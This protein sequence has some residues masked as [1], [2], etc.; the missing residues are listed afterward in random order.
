MTAHTGHDPALVALSIAIAVF[1]SYTALDLGGRV[2][3]AAPGRRWAWIGAAAIAMGGGVWAMH[4]IGMLAFDVAMPVAYEVGL[5][6]LSLLIAVG[7]TGAAFAWVG[8]RGAKTGDV[9]LSGPL[10][11]V[12]VASMHYTGMAAMH[13]PGNLAY[14]PPV[15]AL[16]VL[17]AVVAATA[18]L[19][20]TFRQNRV[21]QK[22]VAAG[23]MGIAVAGMHYTG[24]A[25]ASFTAHAGPAAGA[26]GTVGLEQQNLA[27]YVAGVTFL[28]LFLALVA[29]SI[30]QQRV[31]RELVVAKETAEAAKDAAEDARRRLQL[32][33][34]SGRIGAWSWDMGG[35]LVDAD[36]R[37]RDIFGFGRTGAVPVGAFLERA[38]PED[39]PRVAA[40][41]DAARRIGDECDAEFRVVAPSGEV[42]WV[43]ARGIVAEAAP[44]GA[45]APAPTGVVGRGPRMIGTAWEIT[46]RRRAEEAQREGELRLRLAV[47][48]A[49]IGIWDYDPLAGELR[50]DARCKAL[51]GLP[52]DAPVSYEGAFLAALHPEERD[53]VAATVRGVLAPDGP[54]SFAVEYRV[55][56]LCDGA[57][58]WIAA[59][60]RAVVDAGRVVRLIGTVRD[61]TRG[62]LAR[63]A[64]RQTEERYRLAARAT[65]DAIWDW[66]LPGDHIHWNEAVQTLFG[67][68]PEGGD[69]SG[70]WW[71]EHIH[72]EDRGRVVHGIHAVIDGG[73][74]HWQEDYRFLRADGGYADVFDRGYLLRD[75]AG[76]PLRMIGAMQDVTERKRFEAELVAA[77]DAAEEARAAAEE[78]N[79]AKST[80][81]ANMSHEL[82]TPLSAIIGYTEMLQEE[83]GD[84]VG[85]E[86]MLPDLQKIEANARHLLGLINDVLDLSKIE[87]GKM[88]VYAE[89]FDAEAMVRETA[90]TVRSLMEKKGN[91]LVVRVAPGLGAVHSDVV[92]IRQVLLNLLSNAAKFTE[93]GTVTLSAERDSGPDGREWLVFRVADTGIGMTEEQL[94][95]LFQ[96]FQQADASTTRRFGGTGLGLALT[97]AFS[98][99]L[100][101]DVDVRSAPGEGSTF[102]VRLPA[103]YGE[104]GTGGEGAVPAG[105]VAVDEAVGTCVLVVDDDPAARDLLTRFL[106]REGFVVRAASDGRAGLESARALRPRAI[107]LDVLMPGMDGWSVLSALKADPELAAIP[108]VMETA[109]GE[110]GLACALGA[111]DFLSKPIEWDRLKRVMDRL[112]AATP[113]GMVLVV[114]DDPAMRERLRLMLA[115]DGRAVTEAENGRVALRRVAEARPSLVLLDLAM[116]ELDGFGFL[117]ELR[118]RPEWQDIP[119][120]VVTAKDVTAE[121]RE[122]LGAEADRIV[123]KSGA[124]MQDLLAE[125][126][127]AIGQAATPAIPPARHGPAAAA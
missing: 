47:E 10:M 74:E 88:E 22:S 62:K 94:G 42:R 2:R 120:V 34:R 43:V 30:D 41:L 118:S 85:A 106:E 67:H 101:G 4:F 91:E 8:R 111:A 86:D 99:M 31:Q 93:G 122:R 32:A 9:L 113:D 39:L 82:R 103:V 117:K 46:E 28:I 21:W 33:L 50:W 63:R 57:E 121:D 105:D 116:P 102:T 23:V 83:A 66:D 35:D 98:T 16:S 112:R 125:V 6:L 72:P 104:R 13:I 29:S 79:R 126:R 49:D 75:G 69:T 26:Y 15:V 3:G 109:V 27:L 76:R 53:R 58:R 80:F 71:K 54:G 24:M 55:V 44:E 59:N 127:R 51:F 78:A 73:G 5:T 64:L 119:V 123:R 97:K 68:A 18:A 110:R 40:V 1:A 65:N 19:W 38:H 81:I 70:A 115:R 96:R 12:G 45:P 61:V 107:L 124:D 37:T 77:K 11:G 87:S 60:G 36:A 92:K 84:G 95:K 20:L 7:V 14:S 48:V 114:D 100:G 108:V 89:G 56:G 52:P 90:D 17:I 25:A